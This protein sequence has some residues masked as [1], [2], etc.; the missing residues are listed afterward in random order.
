MNDESDDMRPPR[1][2]TGCL[3]VILDIAAYEQLSARRVPLTPA[4]ARAL[5]TQLQ[6]AAWDL[7]LQNEFNRTQYVVRPR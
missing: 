3:H 4:E 2:E 5:A 6:N 1:V 7:E